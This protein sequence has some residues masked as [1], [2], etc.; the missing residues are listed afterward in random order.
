[1]QCGALLHWS[2]L[3]NKLLIKLQLNRCTHSASGSPS[4]SLFGTT[5]L[6]SGLLKRG[7]EK[8]CISCFLSSLVSPI[9]MNFHVLPDC[10]AWLLWQ[11]F[12]K[13]NTPVCSVRPYQSSEVVGGALDSGCN[14]K[15]SEELCRLIHWSFCQLKYRIRAK[16]PG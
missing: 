14:P 8:N 13:S 5:V 16:G 4:E 6:W 15:S 3:H 12:E 9:E 2:L 10:I 11:L 7:S 1:M